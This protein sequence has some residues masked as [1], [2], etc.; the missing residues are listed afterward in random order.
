M[1]CA[2]VSRPAL[3]SFRCQGSPPGVGYADGIGRGLCSRRRSLA[4]GRIMNLILRAKG[5]SQLRIMGA[6]DSPGKD[7]LPHHPIANRPKL[8][9]HHYPQREH[10]ESIAGDE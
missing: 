4:N 3:S 1:R 6:R 10:L 8:L 7:R 9:G 2:E 5:H